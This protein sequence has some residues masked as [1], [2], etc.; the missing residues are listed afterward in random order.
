MTLEGNG[1]TGPH[2][3]RSL[4]VLGGALSGKSAYAQRLAE[5]SGRT[6]IYCATAALRDDAEMRARID[7][8]RADRD[9]R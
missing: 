6:P 8:H 4:L 9:A 7:R 2:E 1:I 5:A 3:V